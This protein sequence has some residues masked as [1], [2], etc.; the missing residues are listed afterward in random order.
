MFT[1]ILFFLYHHMFFSSTETKGEENEEYQV[2][3]DFLGMVN[4]IIEKLARDH[5][6]VVFFGRYG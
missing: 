6:K 1:E 3:H 2:V 4:G 5:M